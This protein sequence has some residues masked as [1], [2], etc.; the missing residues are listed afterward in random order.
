VGLVRRYS[1]RMRWMSSYADSVPDVGISASVITA[2]LVGCGTAA[3]E[4]GGA[5]SG[6]G[7]DVQAAAA[8][9]ALSARVRRSVGMDIGAPG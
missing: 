2:R 4:G 7:E 3:D 9:T 6:E 1:G 5:V 8:T